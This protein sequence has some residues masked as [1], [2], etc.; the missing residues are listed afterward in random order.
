MPSDTPNKHAAIAV[1]LAA[2]LERGNLSP[3]QARRRGPFHIRQIVKAAADAQSKLTLRH[4]E[5]TL[6][7]MLQLSVIGVGSKD[8]MNSLTS[9]QA[10]R[11]VYSPLSSSWHMVS[12]G[13]RIAVVERKWLGGLFKTNLRIP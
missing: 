3:A 4:S 9:S 8:Q 13:R 11:A 6:Y 12:S 5:G 1:A 7:A 2:T 10:E